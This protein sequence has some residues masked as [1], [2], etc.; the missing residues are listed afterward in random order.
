M[1]ERRILQV[2]IVH[3][4]LHLAREIYVVD[5]VAD[6]NVPGDPV[7]TVVDLVRVCLI[8]SHNAAIRLWGR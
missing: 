2:D 1:H 6:R 4:N 5:L 8:P 3:K 7:E